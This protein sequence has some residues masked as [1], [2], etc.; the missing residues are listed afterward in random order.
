MNLITQGRFLDSFY[1]DM[2]H[3]AGVI[4]PEKEVGAAAHHHNR[5]GQGLGAENRLRREDVIDPEKGLQLL[6]GADFQIC[7]TAHLHA[8]GVAGGKVEIALKHSSL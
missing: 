6:L 1:A 3:C 4:A 2:H 8:E 5:F 7:A